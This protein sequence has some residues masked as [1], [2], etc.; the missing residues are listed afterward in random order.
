MHRRQD[1][2]VSAVL[3]DWD[4]AI[5]IDA[6]ALQIHRGSGTT[7]FMAMDLLTP[8]AMRGAVSMRGAVRHL[9]HH[10]LEAIIWVFVWIMCCYNEGKRRRVTPQEVVEWTVQGPNAGKH[11]FSASFNQSFAAPSWA[12][13]FPLAILLVDHIQDKQRAREKAVTLA[14]TFGRIQPE[15]TDEPEKVWNKHWAIVKDICGHKSLPQL[16]YI[17]ELIPQDAIYRRFTYSCFE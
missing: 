17:V 10:D 3:N 9:Y 4:L 15:E 5:G 8:R 14:R 16:H 6:V 11:R 2:R 1:E 13:E 7:P 12:V